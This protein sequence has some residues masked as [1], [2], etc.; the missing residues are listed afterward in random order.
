M[1]G[2]QPSALKGIFADNFANISECT[3]RFIYMGGAI[4]FTPVA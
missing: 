3:R 4:L 2:L 1:R